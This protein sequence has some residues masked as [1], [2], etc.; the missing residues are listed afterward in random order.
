MRVFLAVADLGVRFARFTHTTIET[1]QNRQPTA[2]LF[3]GH[4]SGGANTASGIANEPPENARLAASMPAIA[5]LVIY[6]SAADA[7]DPGTPVLVRSAQEVLGDQAQVELRTTASELPDS[8]L[9]NAEPGVDG[10]ATVVWLNTE[11]RRAAV[12]CYVGRLHRVVKRELSF[13][14]DADPKERE[15]MLGFVVASLLTPETEQRVEPE[16]RPEDTRAKSNATKQSPTRALERREHFVG[17]AELVG[18]GAT[19]IGGTA[20]GFGASLAGRWL[21]APSLALRLAVGLRRGDI[22]EASATSEMEFVGLGLAFESPVTR[23]SRFSV[24]G[25]AGALLLRH[26]VD[27]LSADDSRP[28]RQSRLIPGADAVFEAGFRFSS[29]AGVVAGVGSELALGHTDVTVKGKEVAEIPPLRG[30][31]ELGIQARF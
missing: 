9:S 3:E 1:R 18:L 17:M 23:S 6:L 16:A 7:A 21:F 20:S 27:H 14:E 19:G 29:S 15:R 25:R 10:A 12:R 13:D 4:E 28:D 8:A 24:G 31:V 30:L 5:T 26:E 22:P 2:I 11:H